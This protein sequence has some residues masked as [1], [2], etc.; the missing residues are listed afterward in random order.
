MSYEKVQE[1]DE[2][3]LIEGKDNESI[4]DKSSVKIAEIKLIQPP[5]I[6]LIEN[7]EYIESIEEIGML[8]LFSEVGDLMKYVKSLK[9][10]VRKLYSTVKTVISQSQ[11]QITDIQ[12]KE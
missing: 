8:T 6:Q 9:T 3:E 11:N 10:E 5:T 1:F 7:S 2:D 4:D 12:N